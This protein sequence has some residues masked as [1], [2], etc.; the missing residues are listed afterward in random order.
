MPVKRAGELYLMRWI[1]LRWCG[2]IVSVCAVMM[3]LLMARSASEQPLTVCPLSNTRL[4]VF[5]H[6]SEHTILDLLDRGLCVW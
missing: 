1:C 4:Q 5:A 2:L 3:I 6:M